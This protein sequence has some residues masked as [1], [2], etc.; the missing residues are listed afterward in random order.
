MSLTM[1]RR[2]EVLSFYFDRFCFKIVCLSLLVLSLIVSSERSQT[3]KKLEKQT[4]VQFQ[5]QI[6]EQLISEDRLLLDH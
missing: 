6:L 1:V 2:Q 4:F 5:K 3:A